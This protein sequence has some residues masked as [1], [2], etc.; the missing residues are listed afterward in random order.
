MLVEIR[1]ITLTAGSDARVE[2]CT[3]GPGLG[4][5]LIFTIPREKARLMEPGAIYTLKLEPA[6]ERS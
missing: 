2:L 6:N 5:L 4:H 3:V 1:S